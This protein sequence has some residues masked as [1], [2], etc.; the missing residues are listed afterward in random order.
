MTRDRPLLRV[1][2][3]CLAL[4]I[5][6]VL[7]FCAF[8]CAQRKD[9]LTI[10]HEASSSAASLAAKLEAQEKGG[11]VYAFSGTSMEPTLHEGDI[12]V[13][14]PTPF[15]ELRVGMVCNYKASWNNFPVTVHRIVDKW[16][17]RE[18]FVMEGDAT[19]NTAETRSTMDA[20]NYI[21]RIISVHRFP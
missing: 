17:G 18:G 5:L 20:T 14:I 6:C 10:Y 21:D 11:R 19:T 4:F 2:F 9:D 12:T 13:A 16:N 1:G 8:G 7:A 15:S 3:I